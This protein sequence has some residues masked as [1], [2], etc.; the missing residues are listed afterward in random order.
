MYRAIFSGIEPANLAKKL[1]SEAGKGISMSEKRRSAQNY[2]LYLR[3]LYFGDTIPTKESATAD[4]SILNIKIL[5]Y[6]KVEAVYEEY[7]MYCDIHNIPNQ[8]RA[9][10]TCFKEAFRDLKKAN[11][12]RLLGCKGSFP[13]CDICNKV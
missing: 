8:E 3:E 13:T 1:I 5:P 2:I 10:L 6:E 12:V 9:R 4:G 11:M 7:H